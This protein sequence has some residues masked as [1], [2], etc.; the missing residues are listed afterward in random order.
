[1]VAE[2][3]RTR[4]GIEC[5][6]VLVALLLLPGLLLVRA[7][8]TAVGALSVAFWA[9]S[10]WWPPFA[11]LSRARFLSAALLAFGL[12]LV[13]RLLPKHQV[14]PPPGWSSPP[15][16]PPAAPPPLVPTRLASTASL[17][18]VAASLAL[19]APLPLWSH[20]PG[21]GLAFQTTTA[22]L[23]VWR[24]AVPATFEPLVPLAPV[25]AHV[26]A[27]ATLAADASHLSGLDP[28][29]STLIVVVVAAGLSLIGLFALHATWVPPKAAALGALV[30]LAAAPWPGTFA[31]WGAGEAL[32]ALGLALPAA[33]LLVGH[34]SRSSALAAGTLLA[35]AL[36]AQPLVAALVV[37]L[38]I[39]AALRR[40][41]P[42]AAGGPHR[43]ALAAALALVLAAPGLWPLARALSA[44]EAGAVALSTRP[45]E[46][47]V[48]ALG[49]VLAAFAPLLF[50]RLAVPG[51]RGVRL[52][53]AA[54]VTV[55][56]GLL[57][58]RVHG[59]IASGQLSAPA[60]AALVRVAAETGPLESVCAAEPVRDWVPALA[61]R[62]AGEPGPWIPPVYADEWALRP[63]RP[64]NIRL[65]AHLLI[66]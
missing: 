39:G 51:S 44:R 2:R 14:P 9:L 60:R 1:M 5:A 7:P 29:R 12:L 59:W 23:I 65:E 64:C 33:A 21:P 13:L 15:V 48:C 17:V 19:L 58:A 37:G 22:R 18:V 36:L 10:A 24:D 41:R 30:G 6:T 66:P 62:A 11:G 46:W 56:T 32:L 53:T 40:C 52:V 3:P 16:P 34:A 54:L 8:W 4:A 31:P 27:L 26:P 20:A 43:L 57:V 61:G 63:R 55:G 25:G 42:G 38:A 50:L 45:D 47:P 28:A 35:A 49:L